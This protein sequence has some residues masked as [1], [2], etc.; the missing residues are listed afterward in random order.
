MGPKSGIPPPEGGGIQGVHAT[1]FS[2]WWLTFL[3]VWKDDKVPGVMFAFTGP[4]ASHGERD[5]SALMDCATH[6]L[7]GLRERTALTDSVK[8][9]LILI[10]II[11]LLLSP[12]ALNA[13][14]MT[15]EPPVHSLYGELEPP[16]NVSAI[17]TPNDGGKCITLFWELSPSDSLL[18]SYN[19]Y[20]AREDGQF[21]LIG[22]AKPGKTSYIDMDPVLENNVDY[23]Y[24][25]EA[26]IDDARRTM[27][28]E[29]VPVSAS[30]Q[31]FH[32][33]KTNVLLFTIVFTILVIYYIFKARKGGKLFLRRIGG[34]DAV[35]EAIGRATEMGRPLL[36]IPGTSTIQDIATIAALNI[37]GE[38]TKKTARYDTTLICPNAD[39]IVYT[40][41][42]E[43]VRESYTEVGRPDS[44]NPDMVY[45]V[46]E[47][48]FA[49]AA[50]C[51]GIMMREKPA[52]IFLMGYFRAESLI[53]AETGAMSGAIQIAGSDAIAQLPFFFTACDYT[54]I[55][56]EL[57]AAS[58]YMS[59]HPVLMGTL[60]AQ[61]W[62]K[63]IAIFILAV[64]T[65]LSLTTS[66]PVLEW[67]EAVD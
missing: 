16:S 31:W 5:D 8:G 66:L 61:D 51:D 9:T 14:D 63:L 18:R 49:Y 17:D 53:L 21:R 50:H 35:E 29:T 56:E 34:L 43:I 41:A 20:R 46:S 7:E 15:L 12:L 37:L 1:G 3:A 13:Q 4:A 2:R 55:G 60:K 65:V 47:N 27:S 58:A 26:V 57:Y 32:S 25:I 28:V 24:R 36:F 39:P 23:R 30:G 40:V 45:F 10:P 33:R 19:I 44:F 62:G 64:A 54:L 48:Q 22:A 59:R 6:N 11:I 42:R 52:T 38:I 67:F